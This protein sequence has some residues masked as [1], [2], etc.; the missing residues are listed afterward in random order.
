MFCCLK[1]K[2][3]AIINRELSNELFLNMIRKEIINLI[4]LYRLNYKDKITNFEL[5]KQRGDWSHPGGKFILYNNLEIYYEVKDFKNFIFYGLKCKDLI[6][7]KRFGK[8]STSYKKNKILILKD[9]KYKTKYKNNISFNY[10]INNKLIEKKFLNKNKKQIDYF[11]NYLIYYH[12]YR[13]SYSTFYYTN[14]N[15]YISLIGTRIKT[16]I[17]SLLNYKLKIFI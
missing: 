9:K 8:Y 7:A 13:T 6:V 10:N 3:S 12:I 14:N 1:P 17:L 2:K 11:I 16:K 4:K 5:K 15:I